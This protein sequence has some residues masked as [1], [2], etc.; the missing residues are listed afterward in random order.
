[1]LETALYIV[2]EVPLL[3]HMSVGEPHVWTAHKYWHWV[4]EANLRSHLAQTHSR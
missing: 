1:M 2:I 4:M 3:D